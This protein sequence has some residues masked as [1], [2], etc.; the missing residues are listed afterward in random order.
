MALG[1]TAPVLAQDQ[2]YREELFTSDVEEVEEVEDLEPV[3]AMRGSADSVTEPRLESS[4]P[5]RTGPTTSWV[6]PTRT[7]SP[8]SSPW[9]ATAW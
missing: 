3:P 5:A 9:V 1:N 6:T 7:A 8:S 2:A 4:A